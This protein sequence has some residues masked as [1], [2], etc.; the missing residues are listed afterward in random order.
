MCAR[1]NVFQGFVYVVIVFRQYFAVV[2]SYSLN[3]I[4]L[5]RCVS[6]GRVED[7]VYFVDQDYLFLEVFRG[8]QIFLQC[9]EVESERGGQ[10]CT[11]YVLLLCET[12]GTC[13]DEMFFVL[14]I[15]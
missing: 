3:E 11:D 12:S 15:C 1:G 7:F 8:C 13:A 4:K 14:C 9:M 5:E 6:E 2:Y 10:R